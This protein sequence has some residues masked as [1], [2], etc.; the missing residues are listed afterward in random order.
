[1]SVQMFDEVLKGSRNKKVAPVLIFFLSSFVAFGLVATEPEL[2]SKPVKKI[3][4]VVKVK[5]VKPSRETLKVYS[6]G[7][8][9]PSA[10][11]T[12]VPEVDGRVVWVNPAFK[13]GGHFMAGDI[14]FRIDRADYQTDY[15]NAQAR[16]DKALVEFKFAESEFQ[17]GNTLKKKK[18]LSESQFD[19]VARQFELFS[20]EARLARLTLEQAQRNLDRTVIK[21]PYR[22]R[23]RSEKVEF[24]QF[25]RRGDVV[26]EIYADQ[27]IKVRLP[28]PNRQMAFM[29]SSGQMAMQSDNFQQVRTAA[30]SSTTNNGRAWS[31]LPL[32]NFS[33]E[34]AGTFHQWQGRLVRHEAELDSQSR[35]VYGIAEM[36]QE[37][38]PDG[39]PMG[40]FVK[41]E[42]EGRSLDDLVHLHRG[43]IRNG[44]EVVVVDEGNRLRVRPVTVLRHQGDEAIISSGLMDGDRVCVSPISI[45]VDGMQVEALDEAGAPVE[46]VTEVISDR[47]ATLSHGD[48]L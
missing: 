40:L 39:L 2:T 19:E 6:E 20:A 15:E 13:A 16:L 9:S 32:V 7:V 5:T 30:G 46:M 42:I 31:A 33:V 4:P 11:S 24:G 1:M 36:T 12:L 41:A 44:S 23:V 35:M 26:A 34:Y 29:A 27:M 25:I 21:A 38:L 48:I 45:V 37:E 3:L 10:E 8:L 28:I 17:R 47:K 43:A 18:L 22:G 14:L